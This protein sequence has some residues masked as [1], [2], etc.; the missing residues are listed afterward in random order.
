[1]FGTSME[2]SNSFLGGGDMRENDHLGESIEVRGEWL[3]NCITV[4]DY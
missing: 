4:K 2:S 3:Y 1:M